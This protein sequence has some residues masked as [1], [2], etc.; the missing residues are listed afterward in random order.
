MGTSL[1][2][3]GL[4]PGEIL[5]IAVAARKA[6]GESFPSE[7]L[8]VSTFTPGAARALLVNDFD[9]LDA[10][11]LVAE[12]IPAL[13]LVKRMILDRMNTFSYVIQHAE[14]LRALPIAFD[15]TSNEAL[16][17]G[18]LT[19][20]PSEH[21]A[22]IW[23]TGEDSVADETLS[24]DEQQILETYLASGGDLFLSGAEIG[25]DLVGNGTSS[26]QVFYQDVLMSSYV[27]D[28]AG[29]YEASGLSGSIFEGIGSLQFD[30]G[31]H[32]TYDVTYPDGIAS[33]SGAAD[34]MVYAGT[35]FGACVEFESG[36]SR[37]VYLGFPFE[38]I[39]GA[40]DRA[41]IMAVTVEY[42]DLEP[43]DVIFFDEFER[44]D[45]SRWTI[46]EP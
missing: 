19:I 37:V 2:I 40:A 8:A 31:T 38:T 10:Y 39:I 28:D 20:T 24:D 42:M 32:G 9:R 44:G 36:E 4:D 43:K 18:R 29:V 12:S 14:A 35:A 46:H 21:A 26:D 27:V 7:I 17:S 15:T 22:L 23:A 11:Q 30:D 25:W 45:L 5:Y 41:G 13:G 3:S 6:G 1:V 16:I 34:C 33:L